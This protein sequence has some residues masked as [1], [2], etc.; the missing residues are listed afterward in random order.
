MSETGQE[1]APGRRTVIGEPPEPPEPSEPSEPFGL[2][3]RQDRTGW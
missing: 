3:R 1:C 2:S